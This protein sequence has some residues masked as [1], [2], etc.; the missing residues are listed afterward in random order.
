MLF[1]PYEYFEYIGIDILPNKY[2]LIAVP[3]HFFVTIGF[4]VVIYKGC[5]L[6][7]TKSTLAKEGKINIILI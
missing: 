7:V 2:W 3:T 6:V 4:I 5:C 1:T